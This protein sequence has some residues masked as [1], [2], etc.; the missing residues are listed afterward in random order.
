MGGTATR[1]PPNEL[2][3]DGVTSEGQGQ[4]SQ[5]GFNTFGRGYFYGFGPNPA[6]FEDAVGRPATCHGSPTR[7]RA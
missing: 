1:R 2:G 7:R 4:A 3:A 6:N 5:G